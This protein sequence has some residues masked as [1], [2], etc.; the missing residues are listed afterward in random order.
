MAGN[1]KPGNSKPGNSRLSAPWDPGAEDGDGSDE[2]LFGDESVIEA[3][4]RAAPFTY[5]HDWVPLSGIDPEAKCLYNILRMHVFDKTGTQTCGPR[6]DDLALMMGV[7][8]ADKL[9]PWFKQLAKLGAIEII[10][11]GLPRRNK[12]R[13]H[14]TPPPGYTGPLTI[15][16]WKRAHFDERVARREAARKSNRVKK[17]GMRA[18]AANR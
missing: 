16:E 9:S 14:E 5:V 15:K 7:S 8:R 11:W 18:R 17:D 6:Q 1:H 13:V 4:R 2:E 10:A 12:Y 3:G